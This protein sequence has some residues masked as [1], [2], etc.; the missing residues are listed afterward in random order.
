MRLQPSRKPRSSPEGASRSNQEEHRLPPPSCATPLPHSH[1]SPFPS[2]LLSSPPQS[3]VCSSPQITHPCWSQ[4]A[5]PYLTGRSPTMAS[6]A[7]KAPHPLRAAFLLTPQSSH[8][9]GEGTA[10]I[11]TSPS[12]TR[13]YRCRVKSH[14]AAKQ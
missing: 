5:L 14:L 9:P 10:L 1:T 11:S 2:R 8:G 12:I 6:Q 7:Q 13:P 3:S 4:P